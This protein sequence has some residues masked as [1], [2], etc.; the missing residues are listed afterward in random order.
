MRRRAT[1]ARVYPWGDVVEGPDAV[2]A[3]RT[4]ARRRCVCAAMMWM[5]IL[6]EPVP[7]A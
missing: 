2:P 3:A 6:P 1:M 7:L 4:K 5:R